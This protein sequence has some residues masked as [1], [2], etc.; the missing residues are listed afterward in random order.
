MTSSTSVAA[1]P[2]VPFLDLALIHAPLKAA[3]LA[4][5]SA[6]IDSNAF[7]NGPQVRA[8]EEAFAASCGVE[9]CIGLASGLDALRLALLAAPIEPGDE[10]LVPANTFIATFEA[11]TQAGGRPVPVDAS[12]DDYNIDPG[13]AADAITARTR[14]LMPV[15]LYGQLADMRTL[16]ALADAHDLLLIEDA[17]QAHSATR[18]GLVAGA[19]GDSAAFS[20]YPGKNLGAFGDAGAL[21]TNDAELADRVRALREH[22][23]I[24]KYQHVYAGYTARLDSI[25]AIVLLRKLEEL[26]GWNEQRRAAAAYYDEALAGIGDVRTPPRAKRSEPVWHLYEIR[27]ADPA[28]MAD[29]L[30]GRDVATGR[31]Y[32]EPP[33][34]SPAYRALGYSAGDFPVAET[35]SAELLSLPMFPGITEAQLEAVVRGVES[36]FDGS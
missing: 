12:F 17:C 22:G 25:Q 27:T 19:A 23:Q 36:F 5:I 6:L 28:A 18:D 13:L 14:A 11:V 24:A 29:H 32:P 10:V 34:L 33:H 8:F 15:H 35:L 7:T 16:R 9:H 4:E 2:R 26:E 21:V 30:R 20:F 1:S 3:I 31:H